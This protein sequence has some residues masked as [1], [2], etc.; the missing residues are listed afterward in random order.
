M[1]NEINE[2]ERLLAPRDVRANVRHLILHTLLRNM[3][4]GSLTIITP[5]GEMIRHRGAQPG[6]GAEIHVRHWRAIRRLI[7]EGNTG[8]GA[9]YLEGDW[10]TPN[11]AALIELAARNDS[12]LQNAMSGFFP[13]RVFNRLRH[14]LRANTRRGSRRNIMDHYDLGNEFFGL[15]LDE[16]MNYS[17]ALFHEPNLTLE[18]AQEAKQNFILDQLALSG[19]ERVLEI[20]C[21]WG[22]LAQKLIERGCEVTGLTLSPAQ[23]DYTM[24]RLSRGGLADRAD[25]RLQDYRDV[26]GTFDRVVS[27]EMLEA[28]GKRFWPAYFDVVR[29]RL[30]GQGLAA[31]QVIT[32]ED[33]RFSSY[34]SASDFI[35][36]YIFPGGMLPSP[37][38]L[39]KHIADG[40][41][42]LVAIRAFG[43]SY[44]ATLAEWARRFQKNWPTIE[45]LGFDHRFRKLWEYYLGYC[46]GGFRS[47]ATDVGLYVL[48]RSV[49]APAKSRLL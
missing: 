42:D 5:G 30:D 45:T 3:T 27:I 35:Q 15:W 4:I 41:L 48:S 8:F 38:L 2:G 36:H 25:I 46:E 1:T 26:T 10:T 19:G 39:R 24:A 9:A 20:G 11:L 49:A 29:A 6:P 7:L 44:A 40:G 17:S 37:G 23:R 47:G 34:E 22:S 33:A 12:G 21:G 43:E 18:S 14:A 16:D 28:V 32:I 13:V 31:I